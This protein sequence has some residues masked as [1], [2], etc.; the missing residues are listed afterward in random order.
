MGSNI[1][2]MSPPARPVAQTPVRETDRPEVLARPAAPVLETAPVSAPAVEQRAPVAPAEQKASRAK[3]AAGGVQQRAQLLA[4]T[5]TSAPSKLE[6]DVSSHG[7][8]TNQDLINH[9]YR[10]ASGG[11]SNSDANY[12]AA[13]DF[14]QKNYGVSMADLI[15]NR[16]GGIKVPTA[17]VAAAPAAAAPTAP[18]APAAARATPAAAATP[19]APAAA[20]PAAAAPAAPAAATATPTASPIAAAAP[21]TPAPAGKEAAEAARPMTAFEAGGGQ[22]AIEASKRK[23]NVRGGGTAMVPTLTREQVEARGRENLYRLGGGDAAIAE[24]P[25]KRQNVRGGGSVAVPA[26]TRED[27]IARGAAAAG[28]AGEAPATPSSQSAHTGRARA[29]REA[30]ARNASRPKPQSFNQ[31]AAAYDISLQR[32]DQ[33]MNSPTATSKQKKA[34]MERQTKTF[35]DYQAA[36]RRQAWQKGNPLEKASKA[37]LTEGV[38]AAQQGAQ[39]IDQAGNFVNW[40]FTKA[41]GK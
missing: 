33:A 7:L 11:L 15:A 32:T 14:L 17:P 36:A 39:A 27:V 4:A 21:A 20:A 18:A 10:Q 23:R 5:Q 38:L 13:R 41:G 19:A 30:D 35:N 8:K 2:R 29:K 31:A 28:G 40:L 34:A 37:L 22:A 9:A 26:R 6:S 1:T 25:T 16:S 24:G 3:A 12:G